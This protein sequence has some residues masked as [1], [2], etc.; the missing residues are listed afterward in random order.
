MALGLRL[1]LPLPNCPLEL[2]PQHLTAP[3][4]TLAQ[5][6]L[7]PA[8]KA[9]APAIVGTST[10]LLRA[11][12]VPSPN[13]RELFEPQHHTLPSA[14]AQVWEPFAARAVT[15]SRPTTST[16]SGVGLA[17]V[18]PFPSWPWSFCPQH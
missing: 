13:C 5:V 6:W 7:P 14:I 17:L 11:V 2:P 9:W 1:L 3:P 10:G 12:V 8:A 15:P 16:A 18:L 4:V